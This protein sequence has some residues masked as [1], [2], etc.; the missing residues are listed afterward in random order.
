MD[1]ATVEL[2]TSLEGAALLA[3]LP[4]Y[5]EPS[6]LSLASGL[7]DGGY[8]SELVAAALTQSRLRAKAEVKFGEFARGMLFSQDGLEQATRLAVAAHHAERFR[9]AG[10][11]HVHDLGCGIGADAMA[12]AS[13]GLEVTAV[14]SD[15]ATAAIARHN[16]RHFHARFVL[17]RAQDAH[18]PPGEGVWLDPARRTPG[19]TDARGRT[20]RVFRL[21]ELS[22]SWSDVQK[23]AAHS[24]TGAKLAP[25]FP[26]AQVPDGAEAVWCSLDGGV[27]EC[28]L[29][30]GPLAA[31]PGRSALVLRDGQALTLTQ[32]DV[33]EQRPAPVLPK[34]GEWLYEPDL[35]VLQAGLVGALEADVEG[36]E[37]APGVGYV[38]SAHHRDVRYARRYRVLEVLPAHVKPVQRVLKARGAGR[39]TLKRRGGPVA[40]E[41]FRR[42]LRLD[43]HGEEATLVLTVAGGRPAVLIV[44]PA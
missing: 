9:H 4:T 29:W 37:L 28:T 39:V 41:A 14:E 20:K 44:E 19:R 5:H 10:I 7:R 27:L 11:Q 3:A 12:F 2:L 30:W 31:T 15:E 26:R 34:P 32:A 6:A 33:P 21:D 35:A 1:H 43:G 16:L 42:S 25:S 13:L 22:P 8:S 38:A 23:I 36:A 24:P 17:G 40:P 18:I